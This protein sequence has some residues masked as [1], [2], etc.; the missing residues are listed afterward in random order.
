M[1]LTLQ[2]T[3]KMTPELKQQLFE[4]KPHIRRA[5]TALVPQSVSEKEFW[6]RFFQY[7][8]AR[9]VCDADLPRSRMMPPVLHWWQCT[10]L[11]CSCRAEP[12]GYCSE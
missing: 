12:E 10:M 2:V 3:L 1:L 7:E 11:T 6:Q 8:F 9:K 5:Y 4:E